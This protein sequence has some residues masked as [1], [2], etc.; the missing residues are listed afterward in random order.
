M[1]KGIILHGKPSREKY[2]DLTLP[3]PSQRHWLSWAA[4]QLRELDID[5]ATPDVPEPYDPVYETWEAT[6]NQFRDCVDGGLLIGHSA[7]AG[8][9]L[10]WLSENPGL[11]P[12]QLVMVAPWLDLDNKYGDFSRFNIDRRLPERIGDIVIINSLDDSENIHESVDFTANA[13]P[14][15]RIIQL[16]GFGHFM[17]GNSMTAPK[18]PELIKQVRL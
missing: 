6:L 17:I 9:F 13:L 15:A 8:F 7:G 14:D 2:F 1:K 5:V 4:N 16:Q 11:Q 12:D 3:P 18:F 10:R